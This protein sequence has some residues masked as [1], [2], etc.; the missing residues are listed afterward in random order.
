MSTAINL[1]GP[2]D[3]DRLLSLIGQY[4]EEIGLTYDDAHRAAVTAPLLEGSPLGT[5]WLIGPARAPLGYVMVSFGWSVSLGGMIGW[6]EEVFIRPSV[7]S[8]GIGTEVLHT[9]TV[10]LGQAGVRAWQVRVDDNT[11]LAGFFARVG[12]GNTANTR[13]MTDLL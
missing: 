7:R 11:R 9:I 5:V 12:F 8:R 6:I 4:H 1:A 13:V 3:D 10:S 2:A